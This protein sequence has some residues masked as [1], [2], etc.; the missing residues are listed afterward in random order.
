MKTSTKLLAVAGVVAAVGATGISL[1]SYAVEDV[2]S[3]SQDATISVKIAQTL[4]MTITGADG[5]A[6]SMANNQV[7][8]STVHT[9][10]IAT[11]NP[12]GYTL[13]LIDKD[14]D[15][16]LKRDNTNK[17]PA[18]PSTSTNLVG[19]T[20]NWGY[21][22]QAPG[23]S[24]YGNA[25][26]AVPTSTESAALLHKNESVGIATFEESTYVKYGIA[27]GTSVAGTYSDTVTY[28]VTGNTAN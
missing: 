2:T 4:S 26:L 20:A 3:G 13:T 15:N 16:S 9:I 11:N 27:T 10:K 25:Y 19:T 18:I 21:K 24:S 1:G 22:V 8:E 28:Q 7:D 14:E 23:A 17:I 5:D 12:D 6:V